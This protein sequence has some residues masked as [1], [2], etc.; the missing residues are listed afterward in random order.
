MA[1]KRVPT[2]DGSDKILVAQLP[3]GTSSGTVAAGDDSR[4]T[5]TA[6]MAQNLLT[7]GEET[8]S[9]EMADSTAVS[10][11][12]SGSL[13]LTY[14]TARK[15]ETITQVRLYSGGT[16]AG[17]TPTLCRIGLYTV[18][19]NG[20]LTALVA[21]T[22]NDTAL[23]AAANT[24]YTKS[25]SSSYAKVAGQRYALGVLVVSG[26]AMPTFLGR[27]LGSAAEASTIAPILSAS[28]SGQSDLPAS[29]ALG[30]LGTSGN[31]IYA[32]LLP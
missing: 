31:R 4:I 25:W 6:Q 19:A 27:V 24:A 11:S 23:F 21:S 22:T 32:A 5:G 17:A 15:S 30:S 29:V 9:R 13:R 3:V 14:F 12:T 26:A 18:A 2:L 20:S 16:A 28:V 1:T 7:T 10:S 8:L